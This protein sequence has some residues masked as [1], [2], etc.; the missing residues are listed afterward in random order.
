MAVIGRE[1]FLNLDDKGKL[2]Y[3]NQQAVAGKHFGQVLGELSMTKE[4]L[5]Q[6]NLYWVG[7]KFI[8]KEIK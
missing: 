1:D 3:L 7:N 5:A 8:R 4:E 6:E 2:K